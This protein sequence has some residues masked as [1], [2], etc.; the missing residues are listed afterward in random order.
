LALTSACSP[1]AKPVDFTTITTAHPA[2]KTLA[3]LYPEPSPSL[4]DGFQQ[5][6]LTKKDYLRLMEG[7][8]DFWKAH[9][10]ADG[11]ILDPYEKDEKTGKLMEKQYSTP[12]FARAAA[13]VVK[14]RG[15]GDLLEPAVRSF[16]FSLTALVK[17]TTA[18]QHAD[19]YIPMLIHAHR[20]LRDRVPAETAA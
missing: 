11:A 8:V 3:R 9:V 7:E 20:I 13:E 16:S 18:N 19:F 5:S 14:E 2:G 4:P 15:R 1:K 17:Q 10:S 12:G 6:G